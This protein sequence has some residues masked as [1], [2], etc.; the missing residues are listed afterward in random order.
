MK[1]IIISG[2]DDLFFD[3]LFDLISSL[4]QFNHKLSDSIGILDFGLSRTNLDKLSGLVDFVV[5]PTPEFMIDTGLR[6]NSYLAARFS[7]PFLPQYFPNYDAYLWLDA[8]TWVQNPFA[9]NLLFNAAQKNAIGIVSESDQTS[10]ASNV[11]A[12]VEQWILNKLSNFYPD[13]GI[14]LYRSNPYYNSGVFALRG[15]MPHWSLWKKYYKAGI[16]NAKETYSDQTALNYALWKESLPIHILPSVCNWCCHLVKPKFSLQNKKFC[17]PNKPHHEIGIMHLTAR[18]KNQTF[19]L[20]ENGLLIEGNYRYGDVNRLK[21]DH[22][23]S[24]IINE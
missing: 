2:A 16:D 9:I 14:A 6:V 8:D 13:D 1:K 20:F 23:Q 19:T 5:K 24:K 4:N 22:I 7:R 10:N 18:T 3:L 15:D 12:N 17:D 21:S 11:N